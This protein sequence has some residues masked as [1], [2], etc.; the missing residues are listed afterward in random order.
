M[1]PLS[2]W[3]EQYQKLASDFDGLTKDLCQLPKSAREAEL[4]AGRIGR[5]ME[6]LVHMQT[7]LVFICEL[8]EDEEK[9]KQ[10]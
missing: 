4:R 8:R 9:A 7:A 2:D 10:E 3:E 6:T 5:L 1:S